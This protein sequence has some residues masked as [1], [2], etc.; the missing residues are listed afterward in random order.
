[1][2]PFASKGLDAIGTPV[3]IWEVAV[4]AVFRHILLSGH[5]RG[6]QTLL[7]LDFLFG[8]QGLILVACLSG[9]RGLIPVACPEPKEL[10]AIY[11]TRQRAVP[12]TL[13][14]LRRS[15]GLFRR[16]LRRS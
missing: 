10:R 1:M 15:Y 12:I 13:S 16:W 11:T 8:F 3:P 7:G 9:S 6:A 5:G 14:V 4:A 2:G